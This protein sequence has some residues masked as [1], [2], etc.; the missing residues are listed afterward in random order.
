MLLFA[1]AD[2]ADSTPS[3]SAYTSRRPQRDHSPEGSTVSDSTAVLMSAPPT[4]MHGTAAEPAVPEPAQPAYRTDPAPGS[5]AYRSAAGR[6]EEEFKRHT[7]R[8]ED[9]E[10]NFVFES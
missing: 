8:D 1:V 7:H 5:G 2:I 9:G 3:R 10:R 6:K 4:G